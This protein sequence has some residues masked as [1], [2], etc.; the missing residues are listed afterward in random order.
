MA[1][2][3]RPESARA[4]AGE[5]PSRVVIEGV[6]PQVDG[7]RFP[8]KRTVGEKVV[9]EAD[10]F[11]EGHD[12]LS[13]VARWRKESDAG[14]TEVAMEP[15]GN[16]RWRA[17]FLVTALEPH[18]FTVEAWVDAFRTWRGGLEKKLAAGAVE[19]VDL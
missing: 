1:T 12:V 18:R 8:V 7:G 6:A 15:L 14:W 10:V 13:A 9:V 17:A 3:A 19:P 11:A 5:R 4:P 16:D 2:S